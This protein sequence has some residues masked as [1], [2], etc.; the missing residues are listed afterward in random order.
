MPI[1]SRMG[2]RAALGLAEILIESSA[3]S[4]RR[5]RSWE[6]A[7]HQPRSTEVE[8]RQALIRLYQFQG[9]SDNVE[10]LIEA[11]WGKTRDPFHEICERASIDLGFFPIDAVRS[12]LERASRL[13]PTD[14]RVWLGHAN[15]AIHTSRHAE[16]EEWG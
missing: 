10:T 12:T 8:L 5:K 9:R 16:A 2:E 15:L 6:E 13:A 14:D 11:N 7:V 1:G 3:S 4:P